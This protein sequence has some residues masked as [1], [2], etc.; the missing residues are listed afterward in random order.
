MFKRWDTDLNQQVTMA[1]ALPVIETE[2][3]KGTA[4]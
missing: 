4:E 2:V 1:E 3:T